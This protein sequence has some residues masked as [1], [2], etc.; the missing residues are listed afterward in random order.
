MEKM[1]IKG[2]IFDVDGTLINS[3]IFWDD[4]YKR[5]KRDYFEGREFYIDPNHDRRFRTQPEAKVAEMLHEIYGLGKDS[6]EML[7]YFKSLCFYY[8]KEVVE[9]KA[10]V[11]ELLTHLKEK[12]IKMCIATASELEYLKI[13]FEKHG[14][15][16]YFEGIVC[17][18]EVGAAKD[19]PDVFLAAEKFLGTP[20]EETW[21]FEDSLL[22]IETS[23]KAGFKVVGIYDE[24]A[25][26]C[27]KIQSVADEFIGKGDSFADLIPKI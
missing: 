7:N 5:L 26:G 6:A 21:V 4:F 15:G 17:C 9:L 11:R 8:Y 13:T 12:G 23:K 19:K 2:A 1:N 16:D 24:C 14:I 18:S 3:L 22:A 20:H 10:G 25:P 27:D